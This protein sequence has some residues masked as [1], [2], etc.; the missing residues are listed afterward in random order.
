[1]TPQ[2]LTLE[3]ALCKNQVIRHTGVREPVHRRERREAAHN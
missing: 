2:P 3:I 1:M